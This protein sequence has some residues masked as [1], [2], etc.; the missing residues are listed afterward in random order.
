VYTSNVMAMLGL[1]SLYFVLADALHRLRYL[2]HGLALILVFT[3][4]KML[5]GDWVHISAGATVLVIGL[6]L[7]GTIAASTWLG[8]AVRRRKEV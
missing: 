2:R 8:N 3:G 1:R 7:L 4:A 6:V 5:A